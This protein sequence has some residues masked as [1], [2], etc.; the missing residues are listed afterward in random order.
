MC[1]LCNIRNFLKDEEW[2]IFQDDEVI[3]NYSK[4]PG[5]DGHL[6]VQPKRHVERF[7]QLSNKEWSELS[8]SLHRYSIAVEKALNKRSKG[9]DEVDK[10]Y[11]WCFCVSPH[12]HLHF[13]LKP[14]MKS[15][16]VA[17]PDFVNYCDP[18]VFL[19]EK[20]IRNIIKE[21]EKFLDQDPDN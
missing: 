16:D 14:K 18:R 20:S 2:K 4:E 9:D 5:V 11:L 12:N 8:N 17:G 13:H 10:I 1:E 19:D 15:V 7:S 6:I 3:V 21:I